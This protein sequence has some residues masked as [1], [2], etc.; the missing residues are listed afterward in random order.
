MERLAGLRRAAGATIMATFAI[1]VAAMPHAAAEEGEALFAAQ[2]ADCHGARD[3][4]WWADQFPDEE[5]RRDWL[6]R[7]LQRHY[8]PADEERALIIDHIEELIAQD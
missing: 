1:V 4:A 6:D 2:C 5:E 7:L 3:I 8:P